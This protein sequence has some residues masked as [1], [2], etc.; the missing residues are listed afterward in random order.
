MLRSLLVLCLAAFACSLKVPVPGELT[1]R[2]SALASAAAL[3]L[4][5]AM[6]ANAAPGATPVWGYNKKKMP[7]PPGSWKDCDT[8]KCVARNYRTRLPFPS[9]RAPGRE[10]S[11]RCITTMLCTS[12]VAGRAALRVRASTGTRST[13]RS[14]RGPPS[15]HVRLRCAR[16]P[17]SSRARRACYAPRYPDADG[18]RLDSATYLP[19]P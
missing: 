13:S 6:K 1:G 19:L 12:D 3:A 14:Q 18:P 7:P 11:C 9:S 5:P 17:P 8:L 2:R 15:G 16:S 10:H 4:L